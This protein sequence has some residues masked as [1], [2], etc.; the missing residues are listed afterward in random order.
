M[1]IL[2]IITGLNKG[3]AE[4]LL[5]NLCEED[6]QFKHTIISLSDIQALESSFSEQ[7]NI[8]VF[9]LNFPD[10][11]IK[12]S[13]I[14]K[15]YRLIK[16]INPDIVQTWMIHADFVGGLAARFAGIRNIFW[17]VH[18]TILFHGSIKWSTI[19]ILKFN[20]LLSYFIP[21]KI[22]YCAEKSRSVQESIGFNKSKGVVIQNGYDV[23]KFSKNSDLGHSFRE[24][25][26]IADDTFLIGHVSRYDPLKDQNTLIEALG[27]LKKYRLNF[28]AVLI[29]KNLDNDNNDLV[30]KIEEKH[31]S[32]HIHLLGLRDD[33]P[34]VMNAIDLFVL[35]SISEAFP[36][37]LNEAMACGVPCVT[38]NVG[39]AALIVKD[40]GWI[41]PPK[42]PKLM[43]N[44][45]IDAETECRS[46]NS[47]W[48]G[49]KDECH[50]RIKENF[51]LQKMT[52][53][54]K[55]LWSNNL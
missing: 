11:K 23:K 14:Y 5:Y 26:K 17:G 28:T 38:T 18:H 1:Q 42:N 10:G 37:V 6:N 32:E 20:A 34:V 15:L 24:E 30:R 21:K 50:K 49:R 13:G 40:T 53:K 16:T 52:E 47:L 7:N 12:I 55:K 27:I 4:T 22:V 41:V 9:S 54:Y 19:A 3:G 51:S 48:H 39:D 29:G 35:S 46:K 44:A 36:N 33:I 25:I 43:S 31:L 2:H 8:N 45:I